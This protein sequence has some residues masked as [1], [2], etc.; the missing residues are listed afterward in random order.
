MLTPV[1]LVEVLADRARSDG[2][3]PLLTYY[4][5][6]KGERVEFS[7][8][9]F[10]SWVGKTANL[11]IEHFDDEGVFVAA[12]LSLQHPAHWT[13]LIWPLATWQSALYYWAFPTPPPDEC[14][15]VV[16][17]PE[18]PRPHPSV[19]TFACSLDPQ[20]QGL[21][22]LPDGVLDFTT[23]V[24]TQPDGQW[25]NPIKYHDG[26]WTDP[27]ADIRMGAWLELPPQPARVLVRP[28]AARLV[29]GEALARPLLGGGSAVIVDGAVSDVE[30]AT[31]A[32]RERI[33]AT[34]TDPVDPFAA[35]ESLRTG[36]E[37]RTRTGWLG[38]LLGG[39]S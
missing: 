25:Q 10:A 2:G 26:A 28:M 6:A 29:L 8:A 12:P 34:V 7:V 39:R 16:V 5:P 11:I 9:S 18:S 21:T 4:H 33:D 27:D 22:G 37:R 32:A 3:R 1:S 15:L 19:P 20:G 36:G 14:A 31:I 23:E 13:S 38:R 17:G 35:E 30:L 24:Q